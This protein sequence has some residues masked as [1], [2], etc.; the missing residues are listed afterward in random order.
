LDG[1]VGSLFVP[2][3]QFL[4]ALGQGSDRFFPRLLIHH[5][6]KIARRDALE[7]SDVG[8]GDM[9]SQVP[10]ATGAGLRFVVVLV[11]GR[12][13]EPAHR[14]SLPDQTATGCLL[15][16]GTGVNQ[17]WRSLISPFINAKNSFCNALTTGPT[18]P[19]PTLILSTDRIGVISAA[20]PL[21]KTSSEM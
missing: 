15:F 3:S 20:V 1:V 8:A 5:G 14:R 9:P 16:T 13:L 12:G 7:E 6:S 2:G 4:V 18:T 10:G 21:K 11:G 17:P 19:L